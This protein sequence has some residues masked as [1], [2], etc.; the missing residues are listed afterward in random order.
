MEKTNNDNAHLMLTPVQMLLSEGDIL[1]TLPQNE[2][3]T[4][5]S[6]FVMVII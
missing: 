5:T 3:L 4:I 6:P 1:G 2:S